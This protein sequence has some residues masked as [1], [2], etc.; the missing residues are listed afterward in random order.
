MSSK[1]K[2]IEVISP[3]VDSRATRRRI[4]SP[5]MS[6]VPSQS[7]YD[8]ACDPDNGD[9]HPSPPHPFPDIQD[10]LS[11]FH[12]PNINYEI[13][14]GNTIN[15][16]SA[17]VSLLGN[18]VF[19]NIIT[20]LLTPIISHSLLPDVKATISKSM[21]DGFKTLRDQLDT[22]SARIDKNEQDI[23]AL[24]EE[25]E[26]LRASMN[27]A[28]SR[29]EEVEIQLEELEQYGRRNSLRFHNVSVGDSDDTDASIVKICNDVLKVNITSDDICRSHPVGRPNRHGKRQIICRLRNWKIKN[30]IYKQKKM[31][32]NHSSRIFV[33]E[34]LTRYRQEVVNEITKAKRAGKVHSFWTTDGRIF[35][36]TSENGHKIMI[37]SIAELN[38]YVPP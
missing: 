24:N 2:R 15:I 25:N 9:T 26:E 5:T 11:Q 14:P 12:L 19:A 31:L 33:T 28:E 18:P 3:P 22:Q 21:E 10:T 27:Q 30:Q 32:K 29:V 35:L 7:D 16:T 8:G 36:K 38:D 20:S 17:I 34:D 37:R 13:E 4:L 1:R 23:A 6:T